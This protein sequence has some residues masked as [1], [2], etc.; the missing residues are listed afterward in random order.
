MQSTG[1]L[2]NQLYV[3]PHYYFCNYSSIIVADIIVITFK[4]Q[5]LKSHC[6]TQIL[7]WSLSR[8]LPNL[9]DSIFL[10][11]RSDNKNIYFTDYW[12]G[13]DKMY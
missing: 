5:V 11:N 1:E 12:E 10:S 4:I 9:F 7:V 8:Q 3:S 2:L 6:L 13:W